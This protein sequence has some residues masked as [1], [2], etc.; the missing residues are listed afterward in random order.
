MT[1]QD[2]EDHQLR[3]HS[4]VAQVCHVIAGF[5]VLRVDVSPDLVFTLLLVSDV[6]PF[7]RKVFYVNVIS[8]RIR[9]SK[10]KSF[11]WMLQSDFVLSSSIAKV[12]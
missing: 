3:A 11:F 10:Y 4:R 1:T 9:N 7:S 2:Y 6:S 12:L 8:P 5:L